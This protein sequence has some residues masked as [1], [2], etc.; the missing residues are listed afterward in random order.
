MGRSNTIAFLGVGD[1]PVER[2]LADAARLRGQEDAL[3]V[4]AVE[5]E[6]EALALL[7]DEAPRLDRQPVVGDLARRD[8]VAPDLGDGPDVDVVGIEVGEEQA[9]G[10]A[11]RCPCRRCGRS[12]AP[13]RTRAPWS[14]R[15]CGPW[16]FHPPL[17][18]GSARVVMRPVSVPASGSVTP[19]ATCRSPAAARGRNVSLSR[20]VPNFTT[21]LSPK[22][23][24]CRAE[25]PFIAAPLRAISCSMTAASV[26]PRPPPPYSSG[27]A[28]PSQP[29]SAMRA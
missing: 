1:R 8:R 24:R 2:D 20:S 5:E 19:N 9:T 25:Q 6:P 18:S 28:R 7:A 3:G 17:P 11:A 10:R 14:S 23:V 4:E 12:A 22:M 27:M 29:P 13:P 21:G 15:S 26:M 16:I